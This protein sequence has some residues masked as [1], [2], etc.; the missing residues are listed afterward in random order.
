MTCEQHGP[1]L[2][3][4]EDDHEE[5]M[6]NFKILFKKL[7]EM[8]VTFTGTVNGERP[9]IQLRLHE[10]ER[11]ARELEHRVGS[12]EQAA[13]TATVERRRSIASIV[14]GVA[15]WAAISLIGLAVMAIWEK[16]QRG[17]H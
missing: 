3:R 14:D 17:T 10:Q 1:L 9:G 8:T 5:T 11:Q 4:I 12:L 6:A 15:K 2:K 7:E 13:V 16:L